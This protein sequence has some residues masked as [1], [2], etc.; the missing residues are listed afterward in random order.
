MCLCMLSLSIFG[1]T[2]ALRIEVP[3]GTTTNQ[4]MCLRVGILIWINAQWHYRL[5][6]SLW[7]HGLLLE[8]EREFWLVSLSGMVANLEPRRTSIQHVSGLTYC[9]NACI[10]TSMHAHTKSC[11]FIGFPCTCGQIHA[12]NYTFVK[13]AWRIPLNMGMAALPSLPLPLPSLP[14]TPLR[15]FVL[16]ATRCP[17]WISVFYVSKSC[18]WIFCFR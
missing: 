3:M 16:H 14:S 1:P 18:Q 5:Q 8:H 11:G 6:Q 17:V 10:N 15:L 7:R 9:V 4:Y 13:L 12:N 2:V